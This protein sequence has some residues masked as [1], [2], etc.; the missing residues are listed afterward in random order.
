MARG[1]DLMDMIRL[2]VEAQTS[3]LRKSIDELRS[4][5]DRRRGAIWLEE[6]TTQGPKIPG[7]AG[8]EGG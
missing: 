4:V 6:A 8:T 7:R 1:Q 3:E 2:E 5:Q